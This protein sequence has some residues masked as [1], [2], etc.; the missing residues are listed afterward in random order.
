[1]SVQLSNKLPTIGTSIFTQMTQLAQQ[2]EA[3]N[4]S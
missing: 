4:L 2:T 3:L 1:M